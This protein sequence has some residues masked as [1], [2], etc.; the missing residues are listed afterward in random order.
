V[1]VHYVKIVPKVTEN[2]LCEATG[3]YVVYILKTVDVLEEVL[4]PETEMLL[5][6]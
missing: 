5:G 4:F 2:V 6:C 1:L 3:V